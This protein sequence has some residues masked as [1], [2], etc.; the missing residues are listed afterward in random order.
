[1]PEKVPMH[2]YL[3]SLDANIQSLR[4]ELRSKENKVLDNIP[5]LGI[6]ITGDYYVESVGSIIH[7]EDGIM[8]SMYTPHALLARDRTIDRW[9]E[10]RVEFFQAIARQIPKHSRVLNIGAGGDI[11]PIQAMIDSEHEIISTDLAEDTIQAL[12]KRIDTS[13]FAGD[14]MYLDRLLPGPVDFFIGNSTLGYVEPGKLL[15]VI[16][17]VY[18]LMIKG[19]VFT[20]DLSPWPSY[21]NIINN[22]QEQTLINESDVDPR[23]LIEYIDRYGEIDGINAM[24]HHVFFQGT[25]VSLTLLKIVRAEFEKLGAQCSIGVFAFRDGEGSSTNCFTLRVSKDYEPIL[26]PVEGEEVFDSCNELFINMQSHA[27]AYVIGYIDRK[28]GMELARKLGISCD[29]RNAP[30]L[31]ADFIEEHQDSRELPDEIRESVLAELDLDAFLDRVRPYITQEKTYKAPK[32][33]DHDIAYDQ[34]MH[35]AVFIGEVPFSR[36]EADRRIDAQYEKARERLA[37]K[38]ERKAAE[39]EKDK[40]RDDRKR[41]KKARKKQR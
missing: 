7:F 9:S 17:N 1:M 31:V 24:A 38:A 33:L 40:R 39:R 8:E 29:P 16:G 10:S 13:A 41:A 12:K 19:G 3:E 21:F 2:Q 11:A 15:S 34:Y 22:R 5:D 37:N 36:E 25:A 30:W 20:F 14:L 32:Q 26:E 4:K 23:K 6:R 27:P 18:K 28:S 35:K